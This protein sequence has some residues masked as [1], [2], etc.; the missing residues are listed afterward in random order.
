MLELQ[1]IVERVPEAM[2]PVEERQGNEHKQI[3]SY[4]E[5]RKEPVEIL[6]AGGLEPSQGKGEAS[7]KE[8]DGEE[9]RGDRPAGAEQEPQ[10]RR[11]SLHHLSAQQHEGHDPREREP[12]RIV[13]A[14]DDPVGY[15]LP[16]QAH[17]HGLGGQIE[18]CDGM[19]EDKEE[20]NGI[21]GKEQGCPQPGE[22]SSVGLGPL[23]QGVELPE[24]DCGEEGDED[25]GELAQDKRG[26][27]P[28]L[29]PPPDRYAAAVPARMVQGV[30]RL[31]AHLVPHG[32]SSDLTQS[33]ALVSLYCWMAP[34][35][36]TCLGHTFVH[37][38]T[39]V[40]CQMPS[41]SERIF[42]RSAAPWSRESM[43]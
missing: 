32:R 13:Q 12:G 3:E 23:G 11:D 17:N 22:K 7:Q 28:L 37:S 20:G 18:P 41:C 5:V 34:A 29:K 27:G 33:V 2:G 24:I 39:K 38:P 31:G 19:E 14:D 4:D 35:G 36:S 26:V 42:K 9:K 25:A 21:E 43:L 15:S 16:P 40:H 6:V 8:V 10:E 30:I 1:P